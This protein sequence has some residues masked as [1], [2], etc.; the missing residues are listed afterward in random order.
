MGNLVILSTSRF[1]GFRD[2][3]VLILVF[4]LILAACYYSTRWAARTGLNLQKQKNIKVLEVYRLNQTK[5]LYIVKIGDK[6][7]SLGVTKD[8][9]EFLSELNED[10]L[11][12]TQTEAPQM[13]FKELLKM[14]K[15]KKE[16]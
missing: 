7:M 3:L 2:L 12:F 1:S 15:D 6:T 8:H 4:V 14:Y 5:Y 13:N 16:E 10:S 11:D 9:I